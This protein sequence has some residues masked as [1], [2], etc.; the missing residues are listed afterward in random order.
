MARRKNVKR[1]D[2]RYFMN[3]KMENLDEGGGQSLDGRD[4]GFRGEDLVKFNKAM[5]EDPAAREFVSSH[6]I[7]QVS[8]WFNNYKP[9]SGDDSGHPYDY[10]PGQ[11]GK[12]KY[13]DYGYEE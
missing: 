9:P 3:E 11:E 7:E 8:A 13:S 5:R 4:Y 12:H 10:P 2:P 1:I 6:N